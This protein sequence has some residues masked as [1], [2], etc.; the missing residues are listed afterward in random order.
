MKSKCQYLFLYL[1]FTIGVSIACRLVPAEKG[2]DEQTVAEEASLVFPPTSTQT[3]LATFTDTALTVPGDVTIPIPPNKGT[4]S[5]G[6]YLLFSPSGDASAQNPAFSPDSKAIL[7]TMF[8][9]GYNQGPAGL[10]I[11][12]LANRPLNPSGQPAGFNSTPGL[13][14]LLF[15]AE[16]D[17]V[18]LPGFNWNAKTNRITFASDRQDIDEIWII[19]PEG[20]DLLRVTHHKNKVYF[21]EPSFSPSGDWIVFE[22]DNDVPDSQQQGSIWKVRTDGSA[23]TQLTGG[24]AGISD[25]RQPNWSPDGDVILF[26]RRIPLGDDW[27]ISTITPDGSNLKNINPNPESADTDASW[28]PNGKCIVYST[29]NGELP[30]PNIFVIPMNGGKPIRVTSSDTYEDGAPSWSPDG[31]WIAFESHLGPDEDTPAAIWLITVTND[32]CK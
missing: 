14:T 29:D 26:Q 21:T 4:R 25:D 17:S 7:F 2:E 30:V 20:S 12:P 11:L 1:V 8:Q 13:V 6:A 24:L 18:N 3:I 16:Y 31:L 28:S 15:E 23:F 22:V 9:E 32:L 27:D 5:D 10:Y 19:A